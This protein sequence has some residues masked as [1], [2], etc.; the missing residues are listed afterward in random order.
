MN[1]GAKDPDRGIGRLPISGCTPMARVRDYS[2]QK[3]LRRLDDE[4]ELYRPLRVLERPKL[5]RDWFARRGSFQKL[6][7]DQFFHCRVYAEFWQSCSRVSA[8]LR[9]RRSI[10]GIV[11]RRRRSTICAKVERVAAATSQRV[12]EQ[13]RKGLRR[14]ILT[15]RDRWLR[16]QREGAERA[17][18]RFPE[19]ALGC[20]RSWPAPE[21]RAPRS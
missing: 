17:R 21:N 5:A 15:T 16:P 4:R 6:R 8:F 11:F 19:S 9:L 3:R 14:Q 10:L 20:R 13:C 12:G 7:A 2:G 18:Q 1:A